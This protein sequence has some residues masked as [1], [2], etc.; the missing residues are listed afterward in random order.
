LVT[1]EADDYHVI[2]PRP[3]GDSEHRPINLGQICRQFDL[4]Y[5]LWCAGVFDEKKDL[6]K[7]VQEGLNRWATD[8]LLAGLTDQLRKL[9][10]QNFH[11]AVANP[12]ADLIKMARSLPITNCDHCQMAAA[13]EM[14][15]AAMTY[16][17][18]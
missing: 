16:D 13:L 7:D 1:L 3:R 12:L 18:E 8:A 17:R 10:T 9:R 4:L 11:N 6:W 5:L 14:L 2:Y 15:Q